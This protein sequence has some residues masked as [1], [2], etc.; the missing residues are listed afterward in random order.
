M[1]PEGA[2]AG[3]PETEGALCFTGRGTD[4]DSVHAE[5]FLAGFCA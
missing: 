1:P 5:C 2:A 4:A 3:I